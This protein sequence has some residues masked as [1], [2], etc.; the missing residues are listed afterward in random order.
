MEF[1]P[2][3]TLCSQKELCGRLNVSRDF[4]LG[5]KYA[6]FAM[7]GGRSTINAALDWLASHPDFKPAAVLSTRRPSMAKPKPSH[8]NC[9]T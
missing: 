8:S 9:P 7:P 1:S 5:M 6:G 4:L 2:A 3:Y